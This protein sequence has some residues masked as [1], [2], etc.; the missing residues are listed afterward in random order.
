MEAGASQPAE[1]GAAEPVEAGAAEPAGSPHAAASA[2]EPE[3]PARTSS[4]GELVFRSDFESGNLGSTEEVNP[5]SEWDIMLRPDTNNPKYRVWFYFSVENVRRRQVVTFNVTNFSKTKSLYREG[6]TPLVR[7][8][9]RPHWQR[10]PMRNTFYYKCPRHEMR[11]VLSFV[12][13]FDNEDDTYFFAYSYP[14]TYSQLQ[15]YLL[16]M[17]RLNLPFFRRT[18][19][20][21]TVQHRR[22]DVVIIGSDLLHFNDRLQPHPSEPP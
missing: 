20:C 12:F 18:L 13:E 8:T 17:Q 14:Y 19:L 1:A 9:S 7:S 10:I 6:M 2:S 5:Q 4:K 22:M 16:S 15:R 3:E 21:R 11:Y